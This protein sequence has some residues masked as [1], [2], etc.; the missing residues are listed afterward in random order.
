M[1]ILN[2]PY[3]TPASS[4]V[5]QLFSTAN[6]PAVNKAAASLDSQA[7]TIVTLSTQG[8]KLSLAS[9]PQT[10]N[11]QPATTTSQT[12]NTANTQVSPAQTGQN[13]QSSQ[14]IQV[15]TAA[16]NSNRS[17]Q[18]Q[19]VANQNDQTQANANLNN[20]IQADTNRYNQTINSTT[21]TNA[22]SYT[23]DTTIG[24]STEPSARESVEA[25]G[26]Q[27]NEGERKGQSINIYA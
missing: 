20:Q 24:E 11:S 9:N 27:R 13:I 19:A 21:Q 23:V 26:I 3:N 12:Q 15:Q 18:T 10:Q 5:G 16:N 7:S 14:N 4:T 6:A 8:Q 2:I 17:V 22:T 1:A 25:A